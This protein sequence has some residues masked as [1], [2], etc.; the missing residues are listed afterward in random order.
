[1]TVGGVAAR[2]RREPGLLESVV[3]VVALLGGHLAVVAAV[4]GAGGVTPLDAAVHAWFVAHRSALLDPVMIGVSAIGGTAGMLALAAVTAVFLVRCGRRAH[5]VIVLLAFAGGE[6]IGD[7]A[8]LI[9]QR[10]RPPQADWLAVVTSYSMP[11]GHSLLATATVGIVAAIAVQRSPRRSAQAAVVALA[12]GVVLLIGTSRLYLGVHWPTDVL[13]GYLLGGAWLAVCLLGLTAVERRR[14]VDGA[15]APTVVLPVDPRS[16][17]LQPVAV[18]A[19][20]HDAG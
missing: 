13:S 18:P 5:A 19:Q 20:R 1:M 9:Y 10:A 7:A 11:S 14:V 12:I 17:H 6:A 3:V 16:A 15:E 4:Q 8:K 2:V